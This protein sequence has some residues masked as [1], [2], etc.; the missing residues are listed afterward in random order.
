M[1]DPTTS[2]A[3]PYTGVL[4]CNINVARAQSAIQL[5]VI[6]VLRESDR[7]WRGRREKERRSLRPRFFPVDLIAGRGLPAAAARG[8]RR[9]LS[10]R[11][12]EI[13]EQTTPRNAAGNI[14][15]WSELHP[16]A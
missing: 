11:L 7:L 16:G 12:L 5:K 9:S 14:D 13:A 1:K 2:T 15:K 8:T 4:T 10:S 6:P 3:C